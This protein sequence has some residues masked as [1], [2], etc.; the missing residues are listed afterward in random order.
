MTFWGTIALS[1][2]LGAAVGWWTARRSGRRLL[3]RR[4][5]VQ[6]LPGSNPPELSWLARAHG[7]RG[8]WLRWAE[9]D[10]VQSAVD[11]SV[12]EAL[13]SAI[14]GR[15]SSLAAPGARTEVERL[16]DGQLAFAAG[17][18]LQVAM[19]LPLDAAAGRALQDLEVLLALCRTRGQLEAAVSRAPSHHEALASVAVRLAIDVERRLDAEVAVAVRRARG[20]QVVATSLRADPHLRRLMAI[21]GSAVDL[22]ARGEA[23]G[24]VMT[25]D[26]LGAQP[27]DRRLRER[28]GWVAPIEL[29]DRAPAGAV[30]IWPRGRADLTAGQQVD[31]NRALEASARRLDEALGRHDLAEQAIRD[32]LSGLR[33]RRGLAESMGRVEVDRGALVAL[34]LDHFKSL[35]DTLGHP[36]G[37]AALKAVSRLLEETVRD[38]DTAARVGGE[39]FA[40]WMPGAPL[41]EALAVAERLGAMGAGLGWGWQGR[42]WPLTASLGVAAWPATT[43][44]RE[45]LMAQAD[46]ALYEAK[47][48]GRNQVRAAK[49]SGE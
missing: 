17:D 13:L 38:S 21:P 22:A 31:L 19:L 4:H 28:Q 34:D 2:A 11:P 32:P 39:E 7:A 37:D 29:P 5:S 1:V 8:I 10:M 41:A 49:P 24:L 12:P 26:P 15:L 33:N 48:G 14:E 16:D 43:R 6:P 3:S 40:V 46:A 30:V 35:N 45:N 42:P 23:P 47:T 36:A 9:G 25:S 44:S 20:V 27:K 18:D